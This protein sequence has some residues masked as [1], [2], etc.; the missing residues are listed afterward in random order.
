[1]NIRIF[2]KSNTALCASRFKEVYSI[3]DINTKFELD[4]NSTSQQC[5]YRFSQ[6]DTRYESYKINRSIQQLKQQKKT[7]LINNN[8]KN[9]LEENLT[10][11]E[12]WTRIIDCDV[13]FSVRTKMYSKTQIHKSVLSKKRQIGDAK[14]LLRHLV[15][16]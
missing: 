13:S 9:Y 12:I 15:K 7:R 2:N 11:F 14:P 10:G 3:I 6:V 5:V 4:M 16:I 1:M 8:R